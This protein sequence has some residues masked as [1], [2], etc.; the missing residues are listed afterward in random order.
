MLCIYNKRRDIASG[1]VYA[2]MGKVEWGE[3]KMGERERYQ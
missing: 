1:V 2:S 3:S